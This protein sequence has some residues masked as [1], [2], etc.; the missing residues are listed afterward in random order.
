MAMS[1]FAYVADRT[2]AERRMLRI[3]LLQ[4][5]MLVAGIISPIGIGPVVSLM[6]VENLILILVLVSIVN[7]AYVY[8]F[9]HDDVHEV[10]Q[11]RVVVENDSNVSGWYYTDSEGERTSGLA[12][13]MTGSGDQ[14]YL[15]RFRQVQSRS[16]DNTV[17][18]LSRSLNHDNVEPRSALT[19][20]RIEFHTRTLCDGVRRVVSLFLSPGRSRVRLNVLMAAFCISMLPT[21]DISLLNLFEMNQPLCWTVREIGLFTGTTLAISALGALV[22]TPVMKKCAEDWHIAMTASVAALVTNVYRF[23]V[24]NSLMMYICECFI[25]LLVCTE[26]VRYGLLRSVIPASVSMSVTRLYA[27]SPCKHG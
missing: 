27:A 6:G 7:F 12:P 14:R 16:D 13:T 9:L 23:F 5:C 21:F 2:P 25:L 24:R 15:T 26:C 4:L 17:V 3:T 20:P 18:G 22:V 10:N 1:C 11:E 19:E 8:L